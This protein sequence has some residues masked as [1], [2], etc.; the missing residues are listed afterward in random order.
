MTEIMAREGVSTIVLPERLDSATASGIERTII[1]ALEP[2]AKVIIDGHEV[3][4][5]S[6]A[7]VRTLATVLHKAEQVKAH[8]VFCRFT[9]AAADCLLVSGFNTLFDI[10]ESTEAAQGKL[11]IKQSQPVTDLAPTADDGLIKG[12]G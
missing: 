1:E 10:A 3:G 6:A 4:Y 9:G 2:G 11:K 5:M 8:L 7:G 12:A